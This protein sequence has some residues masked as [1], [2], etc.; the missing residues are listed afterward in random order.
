MCVEFK[1]EKT[2][3]VMGVNKV[4]GVTEP[5]NYSFDK[6]FDTNSLQAD[7][8]QQGVMPI[9]DSVLEGFNGSIMAYGQT[10]SGKTHTMLGP[11]IDDEVNRGIIPRMV[12]GIFSKIESAPEDIEFTVKVSMIEIYNEKIR[13]L[14]D[15]KK[16]NLKIHDNKEKGVYVKDMTE[17]YVGSEDEVFSLLKIGNE[18]RAI[19][20]TDMNSES[21]RSH[22]VFVL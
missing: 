8:Y 22:S 15:P 16:I 6:M 14:L 20:A 18:N 1:N 2:C 12:E 17:S 4:T 3:S 19:G 7:I 21:S 10:S 11:D 13:D 9:V 5:I